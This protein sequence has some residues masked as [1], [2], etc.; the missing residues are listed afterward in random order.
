M[1]QDSE[2]GIYYF[3]RFGNL[4]LLYREAGHLQCRPD[5]LGGSPLPRP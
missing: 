1:R 2:T 3:D 5:S 4:E